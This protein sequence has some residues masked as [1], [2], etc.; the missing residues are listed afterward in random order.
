MTDITDA[1]DKKIGEVRTKQLDISFSELI[2]LHQ[3]KELIISPEY[4]RLF[5]WTNEQRSRLIESILVELP[6]PQFF[7]VEN[8]SGVLELVDGLQRI[9]SV[10]HFVD[11][12][13]LKLEK[14]LVPLELTGCDLVRELNGQTV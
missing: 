5:R 9:S 2:S 8:D 13:L 14:P 11:S 3:E 1:I 7:V 10:F 12:S 4:Q 6:I